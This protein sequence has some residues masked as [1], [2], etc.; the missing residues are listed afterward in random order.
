M[1]TNRDGD[2]YV[3]QGLR[4]KEDPPL[5]IGEG[6]FTD[7]ITLPGMLF[8]AFVRS[9]EAHARIT[10]IDTSAAAARDGIRAVLT[11]DDLGL[12]AG[13]PMAWA[14]PGVEVNTPEH[15]PL[16]RGE[17]KHVG[18]AVAVVFGDD[19]YAVVD[20]TEDVVVE[21]DPLPAVVDP[22]AALEDGSQLVHEQFGTNRTHQWGLGSEDMDV[23]WQEA[24]VV[25]ERRI[26]NHRTH[27]AP[28]EPRAC[29]AEYRAG[30]LTLW[31]TSQI[32]HLTRSF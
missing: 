26:V 5:I 15:W 8:A 6:V 1:S 29:V 27:G 11:A 25:I 20:A 9:P 19:K 28:I 12:A 23:A 4:R 31:T 18:Q 16:A 32:P 7:D 21:Y 3:G 13:I 14:P 17:V 2:G 30:Y 24:D 22:E 10:S